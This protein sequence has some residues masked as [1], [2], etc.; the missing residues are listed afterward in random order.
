MTLPAVLLVAVP[1]AL[2]LPAAAADVREVRLT[3]D[4]PRP[5]RLLVEPGDSVRFVNTDTFVHRAVSDGPAWQVDT[6]VLVPGES[7]TVP[8]PLTTAGTYGYRGADLDDFSG[9]VVVG[10]ALGQG[11]AT[12]PSASPTVSP[13]ASPTGSAT[14]SPTGGGPAGPSVT[15]GSPGGA[16]PSLGTP[17]PARRF[18]LPT[19]LALL[20]AG[21][22]VSL[23][24]RLLLAVAPA[25]RRD[26]P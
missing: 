16:S 8:E 22:V 19:V 23:L 18:G 6:G 2:G 5:D 25:Q 10:A 13:S 9:T 1:G 24:L 15:S 20:A 21:G 11:A 4:G 12:S 3:Q 7:H 26:V 17:V 14:G